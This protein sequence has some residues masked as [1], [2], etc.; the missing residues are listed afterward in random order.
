MLSLHRS[1]RQGF[2]LIEL[3]VVIA[4]IAILAAILFPVFARAR[5]MSRRTQCLSNLR[6]IGQATLMYAQDYDETFPAASPWPDTAY[7]GRWGAKSVKWPNA[8]HFRQVMESYVKNDVLWQCPLH[9][10]AAPDEWE[11]CGRNSYWYVA[12]HPGYAYGANPFSQ[13]GEWWRQRNLAG[14]NLANCDVKA[15]LVSDASPGS[16]SVFPG[17]FWWGGTNKGD[18]RHMNFVYV[19]GHAKGVTFVMSSYGPCFLPARP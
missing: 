3:L 11:Q 9:Y 17:A 8:P 5:T 7:D 19:D 13:T 16:H 2:T 4:I 18:I 12:G 10:A 15:T 14:E 1:V 6:Q